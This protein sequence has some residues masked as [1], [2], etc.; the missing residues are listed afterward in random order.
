MK[1][2]L[3]NQNKNNKNVQAT[4]SMPKL[5]PYRLLGNFLVF[6]LI[7]SV[8]IIIITIKENLINKKID[9]LMSQ[10]YEV[11]TNYGLKIDDII[12]QGRYKTSKEEIL[13]SLKLSRND[14]ILETDLRQIRQKVEELPWVQ[15]AAVKRSFFPNIIHISLVEKE[16][17]ALW[18]SDNK[19]HPVDQNGNL[20]DAEYTPHKPILVIVGQNAPEKINDLLAITSTTP[21][22]QERIVAA[23]LYAA[24]RWDIILDD[25]EKGVT[26]KMPAENP[27]RAWKKF[28]KINN[29][30]GLLKRKLTFIDLRYKNKLIVT[31]DGSAYAGEKSL[32]HR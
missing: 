27:E 16:V 30:H 5:W 20:V 29:Q 11:S 24:G 13:Q 17:I 7:A 1:F 12:I 14:N 4:T 8:S 3:F 9:D 15:T 21:R 23:K 19:F 18:Q 2:S 26:I 22:I 32:K 28:I 6:A 31:V 10:F 25:I